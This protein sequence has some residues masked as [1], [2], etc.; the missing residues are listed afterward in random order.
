MARET[1]ARRRIREAVE[2]RGGSVESMEWQ[3]IGQ[4]VEMQGREGGWT[5]FARMPRKDA[6][7]KTF[8]DHFTGYSVDDVLGLIELM[9]PEVE[10]R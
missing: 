1:R 3:P 6:P 9:Y 8:E 10:T 7:G 4:M 2:A 5:V